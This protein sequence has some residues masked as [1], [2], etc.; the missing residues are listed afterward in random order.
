MSHRFTSEAISILLFLSSCDL[1]LPN[2]QLCLPFPVQSQAFYCPNVIGHGK[3]CNSYWPLM[4]VS[5][6]QNCKKSLLP[7]QVGRV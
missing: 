6:A 2:S 1:C 3:S 4:A 5:K 7:T